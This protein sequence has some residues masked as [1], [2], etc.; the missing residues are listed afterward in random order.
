[1]KQEEC[2]TSYSGHFILTVNAVTNMLLHL[3]WNVLVSLK[4]I[5]VGHV[6]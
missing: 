5:A 1:V 6:Y 2:L 3:V 4:F